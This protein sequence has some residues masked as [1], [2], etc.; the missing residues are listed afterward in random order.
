MVYQSL[1]HMELKKLMERLSVG[2]SLLIGKF[3]KG[4]ELIT[5]FSVDTWGQL[6]KGMIYIFK[7]SNN[8][9]CY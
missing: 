8:I 9:M 2:F 4:M 1:V 3:Y 5:V 7:K 6:V